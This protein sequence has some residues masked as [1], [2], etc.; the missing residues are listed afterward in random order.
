MSWVLSPPKYVL[1][2]FL[3]VCCL[4]KT[5]A[6]ICGS[7]PLF[8]V[9]DT[10]TAW[11]DEQGQVCTQDPNPRTSCCWSGMRKLNHYTTRLAPFLLCFWEPKNVFYKSY[12]KKYHGQRVSSSSDF[13]QTT[14]D[15]RF[16]AKYGVSL[17]WNKDSV[18]VVGSWGG[19]KQVL[20]GRRKRQ[21]TISALGKIFHNLFGSS[22]ILL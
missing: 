17:P 1:P 3:F 13:S 20:L 14:Q 7:L 18:E 2:F 22:L 11:L 8:C 16:G 6:N 5:I 19:G 9:W 12:W 4:R 15:L 21:W 10:T